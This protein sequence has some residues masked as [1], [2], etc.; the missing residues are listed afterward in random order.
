MRKENDFSNR[1]RIRK[2]HDQSIYTDT[3]TGSGRHPVFQSLDI[4]IVHA[5]RLFI[6][7]LAIRAMLIGPEATL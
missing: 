3:F 6:A 7:G 2:Q 1:G 5:V 4:I